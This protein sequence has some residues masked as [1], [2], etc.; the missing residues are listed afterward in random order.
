M[1]EPQITVVDR[2]PPDVAIAE[3]KN[4]AEKVAAECKLQDDA[5]K[6]RASAAR[7]G[8]RGEEG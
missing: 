2:V 6:V 1:P 8:R 5:L 4:I 3:A 7:G